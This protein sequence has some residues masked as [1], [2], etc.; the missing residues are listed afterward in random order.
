MHGKTAVVTG[1]TS[2]LG[3]VAAVELARRGAR[4]VLVARDAARGQATLGK[5][6]AVNPGADHALRLADLSKLAEMKRVAAEIATAEPAIDLLVNNAGAIFGRREETADGLERTFA[7][8]H[9]A[10]FVVTAG[11]LDR[12]AATPGARIVSTASTAH[13]GARLDFDDLQSRQGYSA[14]GAYGRSKLANILFTRELAR[15]LEGSGVTATCHHPGVVATR[16]ADNVGWLAKAAKLVLRPAFISPEKGAQTLLY[17]ATSPAVEGRSGGYYDRCALTSP[18]PAAQ[19]DAA[20]ARLW[21]A[22]EAI[23]AAA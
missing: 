10:Y 19:D 13:R 2:G 3:E 20:A 5:L 22:S 15:R 16:F 23:A 21:A 8:N 11:L 18:S 4:V 7:V 12:L 1:G 14:L 6:K 9:M 17:L